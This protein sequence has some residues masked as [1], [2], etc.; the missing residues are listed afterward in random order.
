MDVFKRMM[1]AVDNGY[2]HEDGFVVGGRGGRCCGRGRVVSQDD[3]V[4][5]AEDDID[6]ASI[7]VR[8][9]ESESTSVFRHHIR[10]EE[11]EDDDDDNNEV[12]TYTSNIDTSSFFSNKYRNH[13]PYGRRPRV[14]LAALVTS[15]RFDDDKT[16]L[17]VAQDMIFRFDNENMTEREAVQSTL[18]TVEERREFLEAL[19]VKYSNFD[20]SS[21]E[22][23]QNVVLVTRRTFAST[24]QSM[25][26]EA[27]AVAAVTTPTTVLSDSTTGSF[28]VEPGMADDDVH[29]YYSTHQPPKTPKNLTMSPIRCAHKASSKLSS[30]TKCHH[31]QQ[32]S[33]KRRRWFFA[34]SK[35][36]IA[37]TSGTKRD[38]VRSSKT[39]YH[40]DFKSSSSSSA[41][42]NGP[43]AMMKQP[44]SVQ[45]S[46]M[47]T[48][49][50]RRVPID[51]EPSSE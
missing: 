1:V 50:I 5:V 20:G 17:S 42:K 36:A 34:D 38:R 19:D 18:T 33:K 15:T 51:P 26:K 3:L 8:E 45:S 29:E 48:S 39:R 40:F 13:D 11:E 12:G 28:F 14:Y 49:P 27:A 2:E 10:D 46:S 37:P 32:P 41:E 23:L 6:N 30:A 16:F 43:N 24:L 21:D 35:T 44:G 31:Q 4:D 22:V 25:W 47:L 9:E 7:I